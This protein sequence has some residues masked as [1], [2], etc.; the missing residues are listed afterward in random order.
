[1]KKYIINVKQE[2]SMEIEAENEDAAI[3]E[4]YE[5]YLD[6]SPETVDAFVVEEE[7]I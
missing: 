2:T 3:A 4:A 6:A 7:D 1:M 5:T